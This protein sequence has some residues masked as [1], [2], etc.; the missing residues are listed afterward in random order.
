MNVGLG[1]DG[2]ASN[3]DLDMFGELQLAALVAKAVAEDASA[4]PAAAALEIATMGGARAMGLDRELGSL[5]PGKYA[6]MAAVSMDSLS[7]LPV[8][9]PLSHLAY[10]AQAHHVSDVWCGGKAL[11]RGGELKTLDV[12]AIKQQA[13]SWQQTFA[14][15]EQS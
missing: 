2:A 14:E 10:A 3:N 5:E 15:T 6:D 9:N 7:T 1:T 13:I 4:L 12:A 11:L 8:N